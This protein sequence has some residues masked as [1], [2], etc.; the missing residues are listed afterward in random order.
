MKKVLLLFAVFICAS[1]GAM[2][3][4]EIGVYVMP[5]MTSLINK[6]NRIGNDPI[7]QV[8]NTYT[9]GGGVTV[10]HDFKKTRYGKITGG[11]T[12]SSLDHK[13]GLKVGLFYSAQDQKF[14]SQYRTIEPGTTGIVL[15]NHEGRKRL[16]YLKLPVNLRFTVPLT[17]KFNLALYGGPQVS[18][19]L[20]A[21]GGL[22]LWEHL[23]DGTDYY[24]LP[25]AD[26]GYYK[27]FLLD[28]VAGLDFEYKLQRGRIGRFEL[29][30][31]VHLVAG[32]R[33]DWSATT[34]E[35]LDRN[36]NN[37]PLYGK[38]NGFDGERTDSR[39]VSLG[40]LFG[41]TYHFHKPDYAKTR[42]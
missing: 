22:V 4:N 17:D 19:L 39:N 34:V 37:Y 40:L 24:D 26:K 2:A 31:W 10:M 29:A 33:A 35:H 1:F 38:V 36:I 21:D 9:Y 7:Y 20:K 30:R 42:F 12:S 5:Q 14:T 27:T 13:L 16:D 3:Q 32:V 15:K 8:E 23:E 11:Q 41:F 18:Y 25:F 28:A 6:A